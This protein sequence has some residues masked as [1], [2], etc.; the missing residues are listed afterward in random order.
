MAT[1]A[2]Q[3]HP[4]V[5]VAASP[6]SCRQIG[7]LSSA[8]RCRRAPPTWRRRYS[9]SFPAAPSLQLDCARFSGSPSNLVAER[10]TGALRACVSTPMAATAAAKEIASNRCFNGVIR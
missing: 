2:S 9:C 3:H 1:G 10:R 8:A 5:C 7:P 6:S 4:S